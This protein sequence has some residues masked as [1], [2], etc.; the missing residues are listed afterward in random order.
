[1]NK[2]AV[3]D[4]ETTGLSPSHGARVTEVAVVLIQNGVIVDRYQSL[5]N[6]GVRIPPN[7][8]ELTGITNSMLGK[9]PPAERIIRHVVELTKGSVLVAHNA[10]FD[11]KFLEHESRLARCV[12]EKNSLCTMLLARRFFPDMPNHKLGTLANHLQIKPSGSF[13]R[14]MTDAEVTARLFLEITSRAMKMATGKSLTYEKLKRAETVIANDASEIQA[15][16]HR[17]F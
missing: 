16:I 8:E 10:A 1:M 6:A 17:I 7:I 4:F 5:M 9:A 11:M 15:A 3:I 14:A 13:H 2:F 12:S